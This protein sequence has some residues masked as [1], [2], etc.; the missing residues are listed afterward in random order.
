MPAD[1]LLSLERQETQLREE[2]SQ[3]EAKEQRSRMISKYHKVRFFERR[4][5]ERRLGKAQRDLEKSSAQQTEAEEEKEEVRR[6]GVD[7]KYALFFPLEREYVRLYS[8]DKNENEV[9]ERGSL[10]DIV[11]RADKEDRLEAL[12]EGHWWPSGH[13]S[14]VEQEKIRRQRPG[15]KRI[16]N[17]SPGGKGRTLR[18]KQ[19]E[20][21]EKTNGPTHKQP[22]RGE[23][24]LESS[25]REG[26]GTNFFE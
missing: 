8:K 7:V 20:H 1:Q 21:D 6:R 24:D 26:S 23:A 3:I 25:D 4:K 16:R 12:R 5:A 9:V 11:E 17:K 2:I 18:R 14:N 22:Q 13:T 15:D 10:W 19:Q